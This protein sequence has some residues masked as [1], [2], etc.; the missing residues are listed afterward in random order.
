MKTPEV[1]SAERVGDRSSRRPDD[2]KLSPP[3]NSEFAVKLASAIAS[4]AHVAENRGG[5]LVPS[6]TISAIKGMVPKK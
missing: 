5:A 2:G 6:G 3:R 1:G 4:L